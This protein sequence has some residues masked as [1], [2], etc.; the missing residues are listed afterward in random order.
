MKLLQIIRFE[1]RWYDLFNWSFDIFLYIWKNRNIKLKCFH[2]FLRKNKVSTSNVLCF[3]SPHLMCV[4][5][6]SRKTSQQRLGHCLVEGREEILKDLS[7]SI[8]V[9]CSTIAAIWGGMMWIW[10]TLEFPVE[11]EVKNWNVQTS[12]IKNM[13]NNNFRTRKSEGSHIW[14]NHS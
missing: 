8:T 6:R 3:F 7:R 5:R 4:F 12:I 10:D 2:V 9:V 1:I 14:S 13:K 11:M